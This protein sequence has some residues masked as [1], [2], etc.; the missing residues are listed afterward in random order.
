M[1]HPITAASWDSQNRRLCQLAS[2]LGV[3]VVTLIDW[4]DYMRDTAAY[5]IQDERHD[6]DAR[7]LDLHITAPAII[8]CDNHPETL[9]HEL[10]HHAAY[11]VL[12][13]L[14]PHPAHR[15]L[16]L[17][18]TTAWA[19]PPLSPSLK[20]AA[21]RRGID[22]YCRSCRSELYAEL[23]G[24]RLLGDELTPRL[25]RFTARAWAELQR[26]SKPTPAD[27]A[28]RETSNQL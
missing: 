21:A 28:R 7:L 4:P 25:R 11:M 10:G 9:A 24:R 20:R 15:R 27:V 3:S 12:L 22:A 19:E 8:L 26:R 16:R 23:I 2:L 1:K 5:Y 14:Q 18:C 6:T 13:S 17:R